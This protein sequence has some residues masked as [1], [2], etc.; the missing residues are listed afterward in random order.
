MSSSKY[1]KQLQVCVFA[2]CVNFDG[3]KTTL[4]TLK[5][6]VCGLNSSDGRLKFLFTFVAIIDSC[7]VAP[8]ARAPP[9]PPPPYS[10]YTTMPNAAIFYV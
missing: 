3:R 5:T 6:Y 10:E 7:A 9:P 4:P 8:L 2:S 1:K